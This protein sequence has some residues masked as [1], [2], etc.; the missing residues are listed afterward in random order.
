M[1]N[2]TMKNIASR[3]C[4]PV[5]KKSTKKSHMNS[6]KVFRIHVAN[7]RLYLMQKSLFLFK[8]NS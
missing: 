5:L 8:H 4:Y 1:P 3:V 6:K 7:E 2:T